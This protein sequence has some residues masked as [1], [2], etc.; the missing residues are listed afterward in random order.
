MWTKEDM[1]K[2]ESIYRRERPRGYSVR[3]VLS[4]LMTL[5]VELAA[6][7]GGTMT[8]EC[9]PE[10]ERDKLVDFVEA[11]HTLSADQ[12][13]AMLMEMDRARE[14]EIAQGA[15]VATLQAKAGEA[16]K[17]L[18]DGRIAWQGERRLLEHE[19]DALRT[20]MERLKAEVHRLTAP[21]PPNEGPLSH[22]ALADHYR[23]KCQELIQVLVPLY[24]AFGH[25]QVAAYLEGWHTPVMLPALEDEVQSARKQV[26]TLRAD[27]DRYS[28]ELGVVSSRAVTL[29]HERDGALAC[30]RG[31]REAID[32]AVKRWGG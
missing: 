2:A 16:E 10:H 1:D 8:K 5:A 20:K 27:R 32:D 3:G 24:R 21:L 26:D 19:R 30:F 12:A 17:A 4:E 31:L 14:A 25:V 18:V 6:A 22:E 15:T 23:R 13:S 29:L 28:G 11:G 9:M 7:R